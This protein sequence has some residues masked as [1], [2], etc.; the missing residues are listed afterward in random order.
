MTSPA[1]TGPRP[2]TAHNRSFWTRRQILPDQRHDRAGTP[3]QR[4]SELH[5]VTGDD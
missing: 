2:A 4:H 1:G 5:T 3:Q